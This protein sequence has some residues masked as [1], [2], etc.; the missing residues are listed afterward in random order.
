MTPDL[1]LGLLA[2]SLDRPPTGIGRYSIELIGSLRCSGVVPT[3]L[4]SPL[5]HLPK[6]SQYPNL[7]LPGCR[8]LPG[9]M[10]LGNFAIPKAVNQAGLNIVHDP[11]GNAPFFWGAGQAKT[12]VTVHDIFA[13]AFPGSST[14]LEN[15]IARFWLPRV[16]PKVD[17]IITDSQSSATDLTRLMS[18]SPEKITVIPIATSGDFAP[19]P[20]TQAADALATYAL[21]P[22]Y[23]LMVGSLD[24]RRNLPVLLEAYS[25][26]RRDGETRPLVIVGKHR[27]GRD[28]RAELLQK[29]NLRGHVHFLGYVS[30][31]DMPA[32]YSAAD[33]FIFPSL[34]EGFGIPPLE[35]MACGTPV[36]CSNAASLPEVVGDAGL[37]VDPRN[38]LAIANALRKVLDD[39]NL[40]AELRERGFKQAAS[41]SWERT[42]QATLDVYR[43]IL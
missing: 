6:A 37:L 38:P 17:A 39:H 20:L 11:T 28:R 23:I 15:I 7:P 26:L 18:I 29:Y 42:A 27:Q 36:V 31:F 16:L 40:R 1:R 41:F 34:Y 14:L 9:L 5:T 21:T 3:L 10:T 22:G 25:L 32:L 43:K 33:V 30:L 13:L 19:V 2:Y 35:A 24:V 4:G 12:I 8:F